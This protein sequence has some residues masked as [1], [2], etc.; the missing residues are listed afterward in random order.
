M[1][2]FKFKKAD[3]DKDKGENATHEPV[4]TG[5]ADKGSKGGKGKGA[6]KAAR[7]YGAKEVRKGD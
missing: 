7:R 6:E 1:A 2:K 3:G 5:A 4:K